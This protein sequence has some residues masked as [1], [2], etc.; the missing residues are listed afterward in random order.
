[1]HGFYVFLTSQKYRDCSRS[2]SGVYNLFM[3]EFIVSRLET[4]FL[5]ITFQ[6]RFNIIFSDLSEFRSWLLHFD[7]IKKFYVLFSDTSIC[8]WAIKCALF[9]TP[10]LRV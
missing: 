9:W 4:W 2:L 8:V 7:Q 5:A 1:M 10:L 3:P 6:V